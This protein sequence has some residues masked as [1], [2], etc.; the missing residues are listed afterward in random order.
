[1]AHRRR[2]QHVVDGDLVLEVRVRIARAVVVVLHRDRREHL[3]RRAELV[4]VP[5]RERREQHRR[6]LAAR[7]DRVARPRRGR[8]GLPRS[9]CRAS[10]RRRSRARRRARRSR[11]PSRRRGTR[12]SPTG[13]RSRCGCTGCRRGRSRSGSVLPPMPSWP[14]SVPRCVATNAASTWCG[15]EALVD[16]RDRGVERAR[17]HLLVALVEQLAHLDEARR[18]RPRP[19]SSS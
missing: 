7:E 6:G 8:A 10:S 16:A 5:G 1:M 11:P 9:T 14:Q 19:G 18:R 17:R 12:R 2:L 3:A 4:H 15:L 13:T